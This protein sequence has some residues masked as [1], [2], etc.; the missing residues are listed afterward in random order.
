M[1]RFVVRGIG[2]EDVAIEELGLVVLAGAMQTPGFGDISAR[3]V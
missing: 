3:H 1:Q 2:T